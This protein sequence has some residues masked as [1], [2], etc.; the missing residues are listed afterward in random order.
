MIPGGTP[1]Y[2]NSSEPVDIEGCTD[3]S[4]CNYD[5]E[6]TLDDGSCEYPEENFDC[7]GNCLA[8]IDCAGICGGSSELD[9]CDVCGGD[10]S[11][12]AST[13]IES[14]Y[15][16]YAPIGG[17]QFNVESGTLISASGGDAISNGFTVSTG[18]NLVIGF[19]LTGSTIPAGSGTLVTLEIEGADS[20]CI[21]DLVISDS[22]GSAIDYSLDCN[23]FTT[24]QVLEGC[25]DASAC[26]Y[27][28]NANTD[29]GS[30]TFAEENFDCDGNCVVDIDCAGICGG[31]S[32][33]DDCG[34][35]SYT[36]LRA[37]ET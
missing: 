21:S 1:G 14:G 28:E 15:E 34:A 11:T 10:G 13:V 20:T 2:E 3:S 7:D 33:I 30:C 24:L 36:H 17:F 5:T 16:C 29:D 32:E 9:D 6:A 35:V 27:D 37:H 19:S 22:S 26:N 18:G 12:C 23:S 4:A 31:S 25:T 8:D